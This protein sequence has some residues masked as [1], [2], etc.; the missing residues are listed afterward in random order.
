[1]KKI[2]IA[3]HNEGK[4]REFKSMFDEFGVS[5]QSLKDLDYH[6]EV[7]ETGSTFKKN[8]SL[9]A[10]VIAEHFNEPVLADDS[11]LVVDALDG[12]PG[13][14]SARYAGED[15]DDRANVEKVLRKME[16][17]ENKKRTAR[18][19]CVLAVAIPGK[20]TYTIEGKCEGVITQQPIGENGFG[21]DPIFYVPSFLKTLAQMESQEK[22]QISHRANALKELKDRWSEVF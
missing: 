18:F 2:I 1:M 6:E 7:E 10:E 16:G 9:K 20:T 11:G 12:E 22:N 5:V 3:T 21:Y 4:V 17:V 19:V 14:Y 13:V 8:A 15:K